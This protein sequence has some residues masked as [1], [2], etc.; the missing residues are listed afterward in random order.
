[1]AHVRKSVVVKEGE[2]VTLVCNG[3][4]VPTPNITWFN[5]WNMTMANETMWQLLNISRSMA[6]QYTCTAS[7]ACGNDS[8][9]VDVDVQCESSFIISYIINSNN[10]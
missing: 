8:T 10:L 3:L 4:G 7:N 2:N 5:A 9:K 1:M 6:G